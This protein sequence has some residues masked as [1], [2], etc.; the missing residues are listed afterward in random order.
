MAWNFI[1]LLPFL[2]ILLWRQETVVSCYCQR[3]NKDFRMNTATPA[4][5]QML[6]TNGL[7]S[8]FE[9]VGGALTKDTGI[10]FVADFGSTKKFTDRIAGGDVPDLT[11]LTDEAID[12]LIAKGKLAGPRTDVAKSFIGVAVRRGMPHPDISS[13]EAFI[14]ALKS[15]KSISRSRVGASGLHMESLLQQLGLADELKPK[16]KVYDGYAAQACAEGEV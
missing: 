15:A 14:R 16:I 4:K 8:V 2:I 1:G 12:G 6:C 13:P 5:V 7:K 9:A 11:I 3:R 10:A